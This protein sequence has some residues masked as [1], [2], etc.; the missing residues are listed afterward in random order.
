ML[1]FIQSNPHSNTDVIES[2]T[3]TKIPWKPVP[4]STAMIK[5]SDH[6]VSA[7]HSVLYNSEYVNGKCS[8]LSQSN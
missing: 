7:A 2:R 4:A 6:D 8:D 3:I 5:T 1:N